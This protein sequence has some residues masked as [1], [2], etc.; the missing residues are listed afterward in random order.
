MSDSAI[1]AVHAFLC[2]I[3]RQ[4]V[5]A[6]AELMT[7]DHRFTDSLGN[8]FEGRER[9]RAGWA[10][11]FGM[12]PDYSLAIEEFYANGPSVVM[13]GIAQGTYAAGG[14]LAA[15]NRW[16]TPAALRVIVEDGLVSEWQIYAD[17]EP[18]R[19]RMRRPASGSA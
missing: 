10:A 18:M 7:P 3:N 17:N 15:E 4:D 5:T 16:R 14:T 6:L 11:Y 19:E 1:A 8:V 9:M 2:A 12:V 13:L